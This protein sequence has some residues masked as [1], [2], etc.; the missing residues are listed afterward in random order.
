MLH[1]CCTWLSFLI[2]VT[3]NWATNMVHVCGFYWSI[4]FFPLWCW[5]ILYWPYVLFFFFVVFVFLSG[6]LKNAVEIFRVHSDHSLSLVWMYI[7][8]ELYSSVYLNEWMNKWTIAVTE[9]RMKILT[10]HWIQ[11]MS[12]WMY[13]LRPIEWQNMK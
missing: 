1:W 12:S 2:N 13:V 11:E 3:E 10:F 7:A 6:Y 9:G 8:S 4:F 5:I